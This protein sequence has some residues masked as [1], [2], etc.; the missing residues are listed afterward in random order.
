ME[1]SKIDKDWKKQLDERTIAPS[2]A[3]WDKLAQQLDV[4]DKKVKRIAI[5][6]WMGLA[7]CLVIGGMLG[8][9]FW[10]TSPSR[11]SPTS[12]KSSLEHYV[13]TDKTK[14]E[15]SEE[16]HHRVKPQEFIVPNHGKLEKG[17]VETQLL[18]LAEIEP[19]VPGTTA[20]KR[21]KM[22]SLVIDE[23]WVKKNQRKV[24][25][26]SNDLLKQVEGEIEVEYRDTKLKKIIDTTKKA[27]V[28]LSESR[29]E[30]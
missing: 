19:I 26:D 2:P 8:L 28:D 11:T 9:I 1:W 29:Y 18:Q 3:A 12:E 14:P 20:T 23:I 6:K 24:M 27:V 25:V 17:G 10:V 5:R 13:G 15:D 30:K 16:Q 21:E 7:A 22:D 4:R